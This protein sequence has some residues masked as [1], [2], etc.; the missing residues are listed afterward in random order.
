MA[1]AT[2]LSS[3][4]PITT[5]GFYIIVSPPQK[6][7]SVQRVKMLECFTY[8]CTCVGL[9]PEAARA[10]TLQSRGFLYCVILRLLCF[11]LPTIPSS[12]C[13]SILSIILINPR[14]CCMGKKR[15]TL[16]FPWAQLNKLLSPQDA[17][18]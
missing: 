17:D 14:V 6:E 18:P 16:P 11:I 9:N 10:L 7:V 13:L 3:A 12:P 5:R 2:Y 15:T 4:A 1:R 8:T